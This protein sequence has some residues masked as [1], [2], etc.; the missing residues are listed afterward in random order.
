VQSVVKFSALGTD[1]W[2]LELK[3]AN[4]GPGTEN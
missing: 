1:G 3:K 4:G 2:Q